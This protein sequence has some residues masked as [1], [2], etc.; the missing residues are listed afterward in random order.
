MITKIPGTFTVRQLTLG[1]AEKVHQIV[2]ASDL[3]WQ[4]QVANTLDDM[5]RMLGA[6]DVDLNSGGWLVLD[7]EGRA[8]AYAVMEHV[9]HARNFV[10]CGIHPQY[11]DYGI[12]DLLLE[13]AEQWTREQM[14]LASP[15]LRVT[16]RGYCNNKNLAWKSLLEQHDFQPIRNFWV[17]GIELPTASVVPQWP[18]H[19]QVINPTPDMLYA[20]YEA[21]EE[22]FRDHWGFMSQ[23]FEQWR[24][25]ATQRER[26]DLS[27]WF[28]AM[29]G[30]EIAGLSLCAN[31]EDGG[32][33]HVLGVRRPWRRQGL[34]LALLQHSF[35]EFF[36]RDIHKVYLSVDAQS[37]TGATRL[38]ERAG[39]HV[40]KRATQYEKEL[41]VGREPGI[42]TLAE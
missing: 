12:G 3:H 6:P 26:F 7:H 21:D 11:L 19:I 37:L 27:L 41:R 18:E 32:W 28:L 17:M 10:R 20:V 29:D 38:Y 25:W 14:P 30:D 34:A 40:V 15:E 16:L 13:K 39:M 8:I 2:V 35:S 36:R 22:I 1:D 24:Y 33:V 4:G 5:R 9:Q 31:E 42:Q 23:S